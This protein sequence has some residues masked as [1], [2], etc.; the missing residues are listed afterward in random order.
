MVN[1]FY[2]VASYFKTSL[3]MICKEIRV[4]DKMLKSKKTIFI[5]FALVVV[6]VIV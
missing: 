5:E 3:N 1:L 2:R 6:V 4:S